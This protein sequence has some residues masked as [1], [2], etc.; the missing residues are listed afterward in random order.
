MPSGRASG[1]G[2][3]GLFVG[4]EAADDTE[5]SGVFDDCGAVVGGDSRSCRPSRP[6][7]VQ[8]ARSRATMIIIATVTRALYT[9]EAY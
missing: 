6:T 9:G 2:K 8:P 1:T 5:T 4:A 3:V 7:P